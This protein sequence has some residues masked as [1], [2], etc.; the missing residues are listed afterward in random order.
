MKRILI[1][2]LSDSPG[3]LNRAINAI[4]KRFINIESIA[5]GQ[6]AEVNQSQLT[7]VVHVDDISSCEHLVKLLNKQVDVMEARDITDENVVTRELAIVDV[8]VDYSA[9]ADLLVS[10]QVAILTEAADHT[11]IQATG[12]HHQID[13]FIE[14]LKPYNITQL[15]RTGIAGFVKTA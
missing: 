14:L 8:A 3:V 2:R 12:S 10:F 11:V 9:V 6:T 4:S 15:T 7:L 1:A 13:D 5:V